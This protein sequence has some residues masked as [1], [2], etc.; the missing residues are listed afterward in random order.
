MALPGILGL[1]GGIVKTV[2]SG[3]SA[4]KQSKDNKA[5]EGQSAHQRKLANNAAITAQDLPEQIRSEFENVNA[6]NLATRNERASAILERAYDL[7]LINQQA[8]ESIASNAENV[9]KTLEDILANTIGAE[10]TSNIF[11]TLRQNIPEVIDDY[12]QSTEQLDQNLQNI[13]Q[14][15]RSLFN[16]ATDIATV[17]R[18]VGANLQDIAEQQVQLGQDPRNQQT[19]EGLSALGDQYSDIYS[20]AESIADTQGSYAND[21][22]NNASVRLNA[23]DAVEQTQLKDILGSQGLADSSSGI[24]AVRDLLEKQ[25]QR[26]SSTLTQVESQAKGQEF[27]RSQQALSSLA[28]LSGQQG[29]L[30]INRQNLIDQG[31]GRSLAALAQGARTYGDITSSNRDALNALS[32]KD[33]LLRS[34]VAIQNAQGQLLD[35]KTNRILSEGDISARLVQQQQNLNRGEAALAGQVYNTGRQSILD[36]QRIGTDATNQN[37]ASSLGQITLDRDIAQENLERTNRIGSG[38]IDRGLV[39]RGANINADSRILE[40]GVRR[41]DTLAEIAVGGAKSLYDDYSNQTGYF[42][43]SVETKPQPPHRWEQRG[44]KLEF[45]IST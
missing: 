14:D 24:R 40:R 10:E 11:N 7:G 32:Q 44:K 18:N 15:N 27:A 25:G 4:F 6:L 41:A 21:L 3:F 31:Q 5:I 1:I 42:T 22:V 20:R 16:E 9:G 23:Q 33:Q 39:G 19:L 34:G 35:A 2:G 29:Q 28:Q 17:N 37:Y 8:L 38:L 45:E 36:Q 13:Y 43:P 30:G 26:R 12:E